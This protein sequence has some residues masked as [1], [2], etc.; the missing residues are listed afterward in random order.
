MALFVVRLIGALC[1]IV[2]LPTA[3]VA[4][5]TPADHA[6]HHLFV[7]PSFTFEDGTT[8]PQTKVS[9]GT[10]GHLNAKKDNVIRQSRCQRSDPPGPYVGAPHVGGTPGF[11][12]N[13]ERAL[14][15]IRARV[16]YMPVETDL[17]FPVSDAR[18][19]ARFI[20]GV[21]LTPIPSLWGH[22]AGGG[23]DEGAKP[24]INRK[25]AAFLK[26]SAP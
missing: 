25:V 3:L 24:F 10:Y 12:G 26:R 17:Y 20:S 7:L 8:L 23:G 14:R 1:L 2:S 4:Q 15:T 21:D 13:T 16:L 22:V 18:E 11:Q 9:Y 5:A 19:E 6:A